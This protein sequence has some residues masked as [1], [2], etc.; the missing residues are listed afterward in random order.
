MIELLLLVEH[1]V[2]VSVLWPQTDSVVSQLAQVLS[3]INFRVPL[4][5]RL[6]LLSPADCV[7]HH[8]QIIAGNFLGL[9]ALEC[10]DLFDVFAEHDPLGRL[11]RL[12]EERKS[13][14]LVRTVIL[15]EFTLVEVFVEVFSERE[16]LGE[17]LTG[18]EV[19]GTAIRHPDVVLALEGV[20]K[21]VFEREMLS[22]F[23][24][25]IDHLNS[26]LLF[27]ARKPLLTKQIYNFQH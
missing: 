17:I 15:D 11:A 4:R 21:H 23:K 2:L 24:L 9:L 14:G 26:N 19:F 22:V 6:L 12:G 13:R 8:L 10:P 25:L 3:H 1:T 16:L 20:A 7:L 27:R 5:R 18:A